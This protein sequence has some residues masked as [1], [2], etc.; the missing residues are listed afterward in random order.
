MPWTRTTLQGL[1]VRINESNPFASACAANEIC[2]TSHLTSSFIM[3]LLGGPPPA[4]YCCCCCCW[5]CCCCEAGAATVICLAPF[6]N[7]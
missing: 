5:R 3:L 4:L 2:F 1:T 6:S 7:A